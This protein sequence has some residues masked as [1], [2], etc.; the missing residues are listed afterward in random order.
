MLDEDFD[1]FIWAAE[2]MA[3]PEQWKVLEGIW[4]LKATH[5]TEQ[6]RVTYKKRHIFFQLLSLIWISNSN[7][8]MGIPSTPPP[9]MEVGVRVPNPTNIHHVHH[10]MIVN[11]DIGHHSRNKDSS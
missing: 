2:Y 11:S 7:I 9:L 3:F 1:I 5:A 8:N 10:Q 4:G 6:H